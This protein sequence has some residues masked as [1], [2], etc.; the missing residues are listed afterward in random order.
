MTVSQTGIMMLNVAG[1][2]VQEWLGQ[3]GVQA[4]R[5]ASDHLAATIT[6][7]RQV[8]VAGNL[9]TD[10]QIAAIAFDRDATVA[11][12]DADFARFPGL[13]LVNPLRR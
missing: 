1:S 8:G 13:K 2:M 11:S 3:P 4:L 9:T 6:L 10:A 12:N 7:I 5:P